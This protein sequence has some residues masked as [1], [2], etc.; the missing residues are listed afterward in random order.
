MHITEIGLARSGRSGDRIPVTTRFSA[1]VQTG[2][3]AH[4]PSYTMGTGSFP[5]LKRPGR[6]ADPLPSSA[7]VKERIPPS[8]PSWQVYRVNLTLQTGDLMT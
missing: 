2:L 5:G 6:G 7:E 1:P 3:G 4:T 8:V